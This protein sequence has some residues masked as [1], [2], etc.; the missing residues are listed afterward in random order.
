MVCVGVASVLPLKVEVTQANR[1]TG[2][3]CPTAERGGARRRERARA[4]TVRRNNLTV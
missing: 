3:V 2:V 4:Q 1:E